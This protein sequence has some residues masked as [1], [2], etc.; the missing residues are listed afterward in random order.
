MSTALVVVISV[1][2]A[3]VLSALGFAVFLLL[4]LRFRV[5][6]AHRLVRRANRAGANRIQLRTAGRPGARYAV[7][8][9][10]GRSSGAAFATPLG[11]VPTDG[12][13]EIVLPYGRGTDWLENLRA[14]GHARLEHEGVA[15]VVSDPEF[16]TVAEAASL[17]DAD[18][19]GLRLFG[20]TEVV[21]LRAV[22]A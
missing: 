5:P 11:A 13:F 3:L 4:A 20:T 14:A 17:T 7:L 9:H 2:A 21:R 12:A 15:Y 10:R 18:R 6:W 22:P 8:H 19:R 1:M 16:L